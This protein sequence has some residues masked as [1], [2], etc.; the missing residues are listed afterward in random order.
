MSPIAL[1]GAQR[2]LRTAA[3][4]NKRR[5]RSIPNAFVV[6]CLQAHTGSPE[7]RLAALDSAIKEVLTHPPLPPARARLRSRPPDALQVM[8]K[9]MPSKK[10]YT[11]EEVRDSRNYTFAGEMYTGEVCRTVP[12]HTNKQPFRTNDRSNRPA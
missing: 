10:S 1:E 8:R 4:T 3:E 11:L 9:H 6:D 2:R 5:H 7:E 12:Q